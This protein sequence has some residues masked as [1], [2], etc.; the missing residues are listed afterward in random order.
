MILDLI[1]N[2]IRW[3]VVF[4]TNYLPVKV[5]R[6]KGKPFL[7][8]YHVL[9]LTNDG[10]G[11]C[12]H[13]FVESDP[14]RGYYDHP[15]NSAFSF[16]LCGKY[17]ERILND[18]KKTY[19]TYPRNRWTFNF[20]K[21]K[22]VYHRVML[23]EG[24]DV[25]TIFFFGKKSKTWGMVDLNGNHKPMSTLVED[26]DGGLWHHVINGLGIATADTIVIAEN[27]VLLIKRGKNPYKGCWE[28]PGGR[29][30]PSDKKLT[31]CCKTRTKRINPSRKCRLT[32]LENCWQ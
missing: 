32:V 7:Y 12:F 24:K 13:N 3:I 25:W 6:Y 29:I 28:F 22:D 17:D 2:F 4:I 31:I 27:K 15:W 10:P 20:L 30:D 16:I 11:I 9:S 18:D 19:T 1:E 8:R 21:G 14:D 5:I 23:D 26:K